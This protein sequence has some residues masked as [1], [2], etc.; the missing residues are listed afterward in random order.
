MRGRFA[1][2]SF[3]GPKSE[4]MLRGCRVAIVGLGGGG[5][6]VAQQLAHL[7]V[8]DFV[9]FDP[10]R[11]E[12]RN[13]NRL[14]GAKMKDAVSR[15]LK[16][17]VISRLIRGINPNAKIVPVPQIWQKCA[18]LLRDCDVIFGCVDAFAERNQLE[19]T[20]RRYL[21]PYVDIGMDV[22]RIGKRFTVAGQVALSFPGELCLWCFGILR[23][24]L[25]A[26]EGA[27]YGA[28]GPR[29]Q[30]VWPNGVLASLAVG[31]FVALLTPWT[32][33]YGIP[34]LLEY[35]GDSQIVSPSNKLKYL[36]GKPCPHFS[37]LDGLGDPFWPPLHCR[38]EMACLEG[39][40]G[41]EAGIELGVG[42]TPGA[43]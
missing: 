8:C 37:R 27:R 22:Y 9:L 31:V 11:V 41:N 36:E 34:P 29:P 38:N 12:E 21:V 2:Q 30:V 43:K 20:A 1:S 25:L 7:G 4:K 5:S 15:S 19:V 10:D 3:L 35:D 42:E 6:H 40:E 28:A 33:T 32:E 13:L 17:H 24:D 18:A 16:T 26:L 14:V 39:V 23:D